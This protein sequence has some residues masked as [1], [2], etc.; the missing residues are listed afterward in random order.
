M[1]GK[2]HVYSQVTLDTTEN[3]LDGAEKKIIHAIIHK[4]G[5]GGPRGVGSRLRDNEGYQTLLT[6]EITM[7]PH[8]VRSMNNEG[9]FQFF[10]DDEVY[11]FVSY[12][13]YIRNV[14]EGNTFGLFK[15]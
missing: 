6:S 8:E 13:S 5:G 12:P 9:T 11:V 15:L 14:K 3:P 4:S 1:S 2:Y 10:E 7:K